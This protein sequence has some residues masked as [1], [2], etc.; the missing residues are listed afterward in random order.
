[1][2]LLPALALPLVAAALGPYP[3]QH[4][5][6]GAEPTSGAGIF[7]G[8]AFKPHSALARYELGVSCCPSKQIGQLDVYLFERAGVTCAKLDDARSQRNVS[9]TVETSGKKVPVG[10]PPPGSLFQQASFNV[11]GV[12]TGFQVGVEIVFTRVDTTPNALWHGGITVPR[13][14]FN[15]K[16]YAFKGTFAA[17]WCGTKKS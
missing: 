15:G 17:R 11:T 3:S 8:T 4:E 10:H 9:Y 5:G 16:T 6:T 2:K 12:T 14:T 7:A 1:M 13:T